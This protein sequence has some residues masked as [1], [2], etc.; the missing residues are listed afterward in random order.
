VLELEDRPDELYLALIEVCPPW[1]GKG[2]GGGILRW[3]GRCSE[4]SNKPLALHVLRV[5]Q[6]AVELYERAGLRVVDA[7]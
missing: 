6:R 2:L 7:E 3:L 4:R 1:Q 5:N